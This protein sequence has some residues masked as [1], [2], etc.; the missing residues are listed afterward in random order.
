MK[1]FTLFEILVVI[2]LVVLICTVSFSSLYNLNT[3]QILARETGAVVS[4]MERARS[5]S[6]SSQNFSEYGLHLATT[7]VT[8]FTGENYS[9]TSTTNELYQ[10]N[11]QVTLSDALTGSASDFYFSKIT[12]KPNATGTVTLSLKNS[13]ST[14]VITLYATGVFQSN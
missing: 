5:K 10:L 1:G 14:K 4:Y 12:G 8:L 11:S 3:N 6:L 2:A 7:S 9:S 13:T